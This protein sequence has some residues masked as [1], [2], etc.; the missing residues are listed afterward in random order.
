[1]CNLK[2]TY[3]DSLPIS[4]REY[5]DLQSLM[6]KFYHIAIQAFTT[7]KIEQELFNV[8]GLS[9]ITFLTKVFMFDS[10]IVYF[11]NGFILRILACHK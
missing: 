9:S 10:K 1:M 4:K 7:L 3:F 6:N 11:L 5:D 8:G 2:K